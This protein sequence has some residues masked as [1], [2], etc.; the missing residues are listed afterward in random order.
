[1]VT[2]TVP[3]EDS[4]PEPPRYLRH[5][6]HYW[7]GF[8]IFFG[9]LVAA[10]LYWWPSN[11]DHR[12]E[13]TAEDMLGSFI[14]F[15]AMTASFAAISAREP[16]LE[17]HKLYTADLAAF[18]ERERVRETERLRLEELISLR[19]AASQSRPFRYRIGRHANETLAIRYGIANLQLEKR[20]GN[21][22]RTDKEERTILL[23]KTY[24]IRPNLYEAKLT[25]FRDRVVH[26]V[27]EPEQTT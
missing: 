1:M 18:E 4:R 19:D 8:I 25:E 22:I 6:L 24:E 27:I 20:N 3:E 17:E 10:A 15:A 26:V 12:L 13:S 16:Y 9:I 21:I 5:F 14:L 23:Q 11:P 2:V 7:V